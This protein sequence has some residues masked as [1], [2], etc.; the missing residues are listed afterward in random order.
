MKTQD[1]I[2]EAVFDKYKHLIGK[3][4][5]RYKNH[6]YRVFLNC[7]LYDDTTANRQKYAI[8]AAFHDIGIWTAHTFDYLNPSVAAA[9][10][11]LIESGKQEWL[12]EIAM[13]IQF[14]HKIKAYQG[15]YQQ[16][17]ECF[18]KADWTDVSLGLLAF[19][20]DGKKASQIRKTFPNCGFHLFLLRQAVANFLK[21]PLRP[22]PMFR[23]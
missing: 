21:H 17:V 23:I 10:S 19:G 18:R 15:Q 20:Q 13:M 12:T 3:D 8:A 4:F 11:Y 9:E 7:L 2:I 16:T 14:H 6:A 22:L 5:D 1:A